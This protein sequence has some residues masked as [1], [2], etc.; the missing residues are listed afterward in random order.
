[1]KSFF[2]ALTMVVLMCTAPLSA[3]KHDLSR[4]TCKEFLESGNE[5]IALIIMWLQGYAIGSD[6]PPI[7]DFDR[8]NIDTEILR[9][10]CAKNLDT[11]LLTAA[12]DLDLL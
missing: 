9:E 1:M 10:Y 12:E 4:F 3:H 11:A 5:K 2:A 7:V 8:L 6:D